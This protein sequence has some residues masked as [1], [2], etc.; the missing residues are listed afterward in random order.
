MKRITLL[1]T[2][3]VLGLTLYG[4]SG[5]DSAADGGQAVSLQDMAMDIRKE[6]DVLPGAVQGESLPKSI[7]EENSAGGAQGEIQLGSTSGETGTASD[8]Q[9]LT[10]ESMQPA[11]NPATGDVHNRAV[12]EIKDY[13][14]QY[15]DSLQ[16]LSEEECYIVLHGK[17]YSGRE[18]LDSFIGNVR[19]EVP[20]ELVIVQFTTEGDPILTYLNA[21]AENVYCVEDA[22]R[23]A[24]AGNGERYFEKTYDSVWLSGEVDTEGNYYMSL[25]ALQEQDMVVKV[26]TAVTDEPVL[27][28]LP[29]AESA[30][31]DPAAQTLA[32]PESKQP[33]I[34]DLASPS[35]EGGN[36]IELHELPEWAK[37]PAP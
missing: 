10:E 11:V 14:A 27:C 6:S 32:E 9:V 20:D 21:N 35:D 31:P 4:C 36:C 18:Y 1:V 3:V 17:E 28:G 7:Q 8:T 30:T 19:A 24:W 37:P 16:E 23:D 5:N 12:E 26:F 15:P 2:G 29:T 22:S 34:E 13:L 33:R 25:Y